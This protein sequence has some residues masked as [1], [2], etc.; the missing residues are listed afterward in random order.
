MPKKKP[1][2]DCE[3]D[4]CT[5]LKFDKDAKYC[6]NCSKSKEV[7]EKFYERYEK[8]ELP[9]RVNTKVRQYLQR[10]FSKYCICRSYYRS[11]SDSQIASLCSDVIKYGLNKE[12]EKE[13]EKKEEE[14]KEKK[15][16]KPNQWSEF[17]KKYSKD[18]D[19]KY[20]DAARD[21]VVKQIYKSFVESKK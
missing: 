3:N 5:L 21:P 12:E 13:E 14:K 4:F 7:F 11:S 6:E 16:R 15:K 10:K 18:H 17:V 19:I 9:Q 20:W 1:E 2:D 8:N